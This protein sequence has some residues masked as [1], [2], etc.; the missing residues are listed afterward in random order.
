MK[1]I[2][3]VI[4]VFVHGFIFWIMLHK[5]LLLTSS[6][7]Q[8]TQAAG[9]DTVIGTNMN[10]QMVTAVTKKKPTKAIVKQPVN[11]LASEPTSKTTKPAAADSPDLNSQKLGLKQEKAL[12]DKNK[13]TTKNTLLTKVSKVDDSAVD[14]I[15][16]NHTVDTKPSTVKTMLKTASD[17]QTI[18]SNRGVSLAGDNAKESQINTGNE[19]SSEKVAWDSYKS[20]VFSAINAQKIYP[21]QAKLRRAEGTV[22]VKFAITKTGNISNFELVKKVSSEHLNRSTA[23][24]FNQLYLPATPVSVGEYLPAILTVPIEYSL[25]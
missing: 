21:K 25:N 5:S 20:A 19:I 3:L 1:V 7:N 2:A 8:V 22:V 14:A 15:K 13:S 6:N 4:S 12:M 11:E 9:L 17:K 10:I 24:L 16:K 23:R 18:V